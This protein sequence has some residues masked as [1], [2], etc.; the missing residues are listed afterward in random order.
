MANAFDLIVIGAHLGSLSHDVDEIARRLDKYP[1]FYVEPAE[2]TKQLTRQSA[3]KVREL[4]I[5]YQDRITYGTDVRFGKYI[6]PVPEEEYDDLVKLT[7]EYYRRDYQYYAGSGTVEY[8]GKEVD[9][10]NL[11]AEVLEKFY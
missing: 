11:P 10:L 1:N 4:F 3:W 5:K 8:F 6:R 7:E 9:C 2:R